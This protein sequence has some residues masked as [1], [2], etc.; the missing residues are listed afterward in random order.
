MAVGRA[1]DWLCYICDDGP[2]T[3][4]PWVMEHVQ[5]WKHKGPS[6][7]S[8]LKLAH[9]SCNSHKGDHSWIL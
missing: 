4:D 9:K 5:S 6:N 7:L 3:A 1:C 8:N 2:D